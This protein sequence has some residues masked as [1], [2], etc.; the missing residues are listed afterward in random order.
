M[1]NQRV[2]LALW[3]DAAGFTTATT[4][5]AAQRN[6]TT[7]YTE[8]PREAVDQIKDYLRWLARREEWYAETELDDVEVR[9]LRIRARPRYGDET[10]ELH[11][12]TTIEL[13]LPCVTG[14]LRQSNWLG[15]IPTMRLSFLVH[16]RSSVLQVAEEQVRAHLAR[17]RTDDIVGLLGVRDVELR[18]IS[19]PLPPAKMNLHRTARWPNLE[20]VATPLAKPVRGRKTNSVFQRETEI[21][22]LT[23][24]LTEQ[25]AS[26]VLVGDESVG[27]SGILTHAARGLV[28]HVRSQSPTATHP[29]WLTNG[30][31]LIAGMKY[32]GQWEERCEQ[33]INALSS[34]SGWLCVESISDLIATGG[35]DPS[36]SIAAFLLPYL[37]HAQLKMVCEASPAELIAAERMLPEFVEAFT[38][39]PIERLDGRRCDLAIEQGAAIICQQEKIEFAPGVTQHT[40]QLARRFEP[41][42][43]PLATAMNLLRR[44]A[45]SANK[46]KAER[47]TD[48]DALEAYAE[49]TGLRLDVLLDQ[50]Q[51][52]YND[53]IQSLEK[54]VV[55]QS[56]ACR[57][58]ATVV[59]TFKAGLHS[60]DR[61]LGVLL[62]CGPTGVGKTQLA[63]SLGKY[64]F[65]HSRD[66]TLVRLDMSE[67]GGMSA[68]DRLLTKPDGSPSGWIQRIRKQPFGVLLL[69][70][71][72]KANPLV[73]DV[74][75][76]LMD[77]GRLTD[78]FGRVT[79][80]H[81][82]IVIMTSN[83]GSTSS[84]KIGF[85]GSSNERFESAVREFF[86]PEFC[87]RIDRVVPFSSL[88]SDDCRQI[89]AME[90]SALQERAG[91]KRRGITLKFDE[92][93]VDLLIETGLDESLGARPLQRSLEKNVTAVLAR[94]L[95]Q[96]HR[97]RDATLYV[98]RA[99][100]TISVGVDK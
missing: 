79:N 74:L 40:L 8:K 7:A 88:A 19:I 26:L 9:H 55:G 28:K 61:P 52:P 31:R 70:E 13:R 76:G 66:D 25:S 1:P 6:A 30:G 48:D 57:S 81:S 42:R 46:A 71:I 65:G 10:S 33:V 73:F 36:S 91:F 15:V 97:V 4:I 67:Y 50:V 12:P 35:R 86:R 63:K 27:K 43:P 90:L 80:F 96:D 59:T 2:H 72:E 14:K 78:T 38:R 69:D 85:D 83:L 18:E 22:Q 92:A 77:E 95:A 3:K 58:V 93:V 62:F 39:I 16:S 20:S 29:I 21:A 89:V 56:V 34:F 99:G 47:V 24:R 23:K 41:Y 44:I 100:D 87:N 11:L 45:S 51:L 82:T 49:R 54:E 98:R 5:Q 94:F 60:P 37:R 32:L 68:A 17:A 53:V 64:L 75:M 84:A